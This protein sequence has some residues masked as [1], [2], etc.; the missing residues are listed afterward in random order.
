[1]DYGMVPKLNQFTDNQ[2]L[3]VQKVQTSSQSAEIKN[4][5]NL[6]SIQQKAIE[7]TKESS[8][9]QQVQN[10]Q[11]STAS[12]Y[13]VLLTNTNFG[14]NSNSRDFYVKVER[15]SVENQYPTEQMM[16]VKAHMQA[17]QESLNS[18]A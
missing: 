6:E 14:Y 5:Q 17:L 4:K 18:Q 16:K 15:G 2:A 8:A 13:E 9:A 11:P 10:Q 1:M 7:K 12:K 3:E